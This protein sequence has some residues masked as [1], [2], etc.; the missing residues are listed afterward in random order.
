[1]TYFLSANFTN[2][3]HTTMN[4]CRIYLKILTISDMATGDGR[5]ILRNVWEGRAKQKDIRGF[6]WPKQGCLNEQE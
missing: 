1:M 6:Q 2:V 5:T 4:W 3:E